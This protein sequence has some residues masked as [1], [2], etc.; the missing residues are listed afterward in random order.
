MGDT[1]AGANRGCQLDGPS[2]IMVVG[3]TKPEL[4]K[5]EGWRLDRI[6][7]DRGRPWTETLVDVVLAED[8]RAGKITFS[9]SD[10]NVAM[11]LAQ[12][13]V[14][15]GSDAEG[16]D[17]ATAK[18]RTHPRAYGTFARVLGKY[19]RDDHVLTLEDGVRKMTSAAA[20]RLGLHDRGLL[21]QG[22]FADVAVFDA[23]TI[24]DRA[25]YEQPH[26]L[27]VGVDVVLVN[28]VAV[29]R[30]GAATGASPGR[31]LRGAG[32]AP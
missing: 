22:M 25:T 6:A 32:Y 11:Q 8:G 15:I 3:L 24:A 30:N 29:W 1:S 7:A 21:R 12:P 23:A 20:A 16:F 2:V 5:Y 14:T 18:G 27:A 31:A 13:W 28:G 19:V 17:P 9:M 10:A 26:Q 4:R